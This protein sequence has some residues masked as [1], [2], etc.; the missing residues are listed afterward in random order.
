MMIIQKELI[1]YLIIFMLEGL[2]SV[3]NLNYFSTLFFYYYMQLNHIIIKNTNRINNI[4]YTKA[5]TNNF[6]YLDLD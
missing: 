2:I 5:F 3:I 6:S 4:G 1:I